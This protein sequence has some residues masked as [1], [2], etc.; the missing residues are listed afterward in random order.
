MFY[1]GQNQLK[2]EV[3][4]TRMNSDATTYSV[5]QLQVLQLQM[6]QLGQLAAE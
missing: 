3:A 1:R 6:L 5:L 4:P 2:F